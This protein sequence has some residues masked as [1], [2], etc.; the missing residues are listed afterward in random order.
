MGEL[1]TTRGIKTMIYK[2]YKK[3]KPISTLHFIE[4]KTERQAKIKYCGN[5]FKWIFS[6]NL[7]SKKKNY[8]NKRFKKGT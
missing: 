6:T 2:V 1:L 3:H 8:E 7:I 5:W 4:A